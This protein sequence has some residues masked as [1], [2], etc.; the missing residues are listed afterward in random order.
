MINTLT[1]PK[2]KVDVSGGIWIGSWRPISHVTEYDLAF[3]A[4]YEF[5]EAMKNGVGLR[6]HPCNCAQ[7]CLVR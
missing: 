3:F 1:S 4:C 7:E 5:L 2:R 6:E